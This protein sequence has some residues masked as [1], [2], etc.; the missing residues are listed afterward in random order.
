[1]KKTGL[2]TQKILEEYIAD[3]ISLNKHMCEYQEKNI[4]IIKN[5]QQK[6]S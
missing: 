1:M 2:D 6:S 4:M 3:V 5:S